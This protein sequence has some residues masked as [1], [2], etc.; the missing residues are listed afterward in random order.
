MYFKSFD[1]TSNKGIGIVEIVISLFILSLFLLVSLTYFHKYQKDMQIKLTSQEILSI[2]SFARNSALNE[3]K[4]FVVIF[5]ENSV[6]VK[7]E[8]QEAIVGKQYRFR[9]R[10]YVKE[11]SQG[12]NPII[13]Q[14]D[15]TSKMAGFMVLA[16]TSGGKEVRLVLHN[17][18]GRCFIEK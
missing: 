9:E 13:L 1:K 5:D 6:V 4:N 18:T 7:R 2:I 16:D 12:F 17:L 11:K 8:G 10:I 3:R 15:G 14:P